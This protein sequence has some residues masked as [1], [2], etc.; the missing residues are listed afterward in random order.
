VPDRFHGVQ[1]RHAVAAV[2]DGALGDIE[3]DPLV[4]LG[5]TQ[6]DS[7]DEDVFGNVAARGARSRRSA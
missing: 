4:G 6:V 3:L 5:D 1:A 7:D 2:V